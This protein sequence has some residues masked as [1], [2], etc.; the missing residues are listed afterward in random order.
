MSLVGDYDPQNVF[1]K[2][3]KGELPAT[4]IYEDDV[5]VAIMDLFPQS[6]G[7]ALVIPKS[8]SRHLLDADPLSLSEVIKRVQ[9]LAQAVKDALHPDGIVMTQFN[10]A[11]AG[12]TV[13]HLHFHIIPRYENED[14]SPHAA[15]KMADPA[16]LKVLADQIRSKLHP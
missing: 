15:G 7:H 2:I 11:P 4:K 10:G 12:Q 1:A 8:P 9:T 3:L 6:R 13:F 14:L 16:E 5:V